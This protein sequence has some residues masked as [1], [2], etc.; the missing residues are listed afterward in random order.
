M[1]RTIALTGLVTAAL[2]VAAPAR[3]AFTE[4]TDPVEWQNAV[5]DYE[6]ITFTEFPVDTL[7]GDQYSDLG[8]HFT[9]GNDYIYQAAA[10]DSDMRGVDGNGNITLAFDTPQ[11]WI[12]VDYPGFIQIELYK[13]AALLYQSSIFVHESFAGLLSAQAFDTAVLIDPAG[14]AEI[15]NLYFG[16]PAPSGLAVF[17]A[18]LALG[19]RRRRCA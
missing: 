1:M 8:V 4:Y 15:D 5:G 16:V 14:E 12:A 17:G 9:D 2:L 19:G 11:Q 3:A 18:F 13:D 10:F 7:L 6:T